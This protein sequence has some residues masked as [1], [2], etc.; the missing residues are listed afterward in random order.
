MYDVVKRLG[1]CC[2]ASLEILRGMILVSIQSF[3]PILP[4]H[5]HDKQYWTASV[6]E[7]HHSQH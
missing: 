5:L 6:L 3:C 7:P 2:E 4:S 1:N